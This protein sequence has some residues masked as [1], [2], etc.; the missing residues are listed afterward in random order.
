MPDLKCQLMRSFILKK[1]GAYLIKQNEFPRGSKAFVLGGGPYDRSKEAARLYQAG[2]V[3]ELICT[4]ISQN[5]DYTVLGE[6]FPE[7]KITRAGLLQNG[8]PEA[9]IKALKAAMTTREEVEAI[10]GYCEQ[11]NIAEAVIITHKFHTRRVFS[12]VKYWHKKSKVK[13]YL[14]GAFSHYYDEKYWWKHTV[15]FFTV[16][17]EY[18]KLLVYKLKKIF[19]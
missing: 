18:I 16:Q 14:H 5:N 2:E 9:N 1:I 6:E 4:G 13:L 17:N 11:N 15:G 8:V 19:R 7:W 12:E 10:I 3:S